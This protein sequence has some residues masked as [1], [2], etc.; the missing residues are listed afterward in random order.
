MLHIRNYF[1]GVDEI[2]N[3]RKDGSLYVGTVRSGE[4]RDFDKE[5]T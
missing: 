3:G 2:E 4:S 5:V 1:F